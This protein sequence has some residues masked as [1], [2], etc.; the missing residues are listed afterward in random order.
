MEKYYR[1]GQDFFLLVQ[2]KGVSKEPT[3]ELQI[4][5]NFKELM[6]QKALVKEKNTERR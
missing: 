4:P 5:S 1:K 3:Y 6:D 2:P